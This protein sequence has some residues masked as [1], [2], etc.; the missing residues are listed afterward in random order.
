MVLAAST[1]L[2]RY[3]CRQPGGPLTGHPRASGPP[4]SR[5]RH[6]RPVR[7]PDADYPMYRT[8][9]AEFRLQP[10]QRC[11]LPVPETALETVTR[12]HTWPASQSP[13]EPVTGALPS[14]REQSTA[15]RLH[16]RPKLPMMAGQNQ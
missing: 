7:P 4:P 14:S 8:V 3:P 12:H 5:P 15:S 9:P 1:I 10:A 2:N 16:P 6:Q 11:L 13:P